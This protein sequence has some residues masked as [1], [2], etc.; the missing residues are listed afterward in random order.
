MKE[1]KLTVTTPTEREVVL[2]R[3]FDAQPALVFDALTKPD[4][5]KLWYGPAGW[6]LDIC[7]VD[8][9]VGGKWRFVSRNPT[10]KQIGQFGVYHEIERPS[11]IANSESWE[12]WDAGETFVT[13]LLFGLHG[14]TKL[15]STILFPS[16]EVRDIVLKNG[17]EH[18]VEAGYNKLADVLAS[19]GKG[20]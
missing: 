18:G 13:N 11:L 20:V 7:E 17:L 6:S 4:L 12:D 16:Q 2:T 9:K 14:Q 3:V 10:G 15:T 5:I 19:I 8:L 1:G